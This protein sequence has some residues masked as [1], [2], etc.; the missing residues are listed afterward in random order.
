MGM[1]HGISHDIAGERIKFVIKSRKIFTQN[2]SWETY[3]GKPPF[4]RPFWIWWDDWER[5][6]G[7]V[8]KKIAECVMFWRELKLRGA[9]QRRAVVSIVINRRIL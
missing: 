5:G 1:I 6:G 9:V 7:G 2:A 8:Y 4:R 3:I